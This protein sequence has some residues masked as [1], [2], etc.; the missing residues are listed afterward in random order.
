MKIVYH[1][2]AHCTDDDRLLRCLLKNRARLSAAGVVVP[3]PARYRRLLRD[4]AVQL[5][6]QRA[7][8]E[9]QALVLDQ[10]MDEAEAERLILSW[11]SFL[12]FPQWA[13]QDGLYPMAGERIRAF[14][15]IFPEIAAEF[16]L[17]IR[18]P[19]TFLPALFDK[20]KVKSLPE[21]LDGTDPMALRW[22]DVIARIR[23][24]NPGITLTIWCDEDTPLI[25]PDVLARVT[26]MPEGTVFD[27]QDELLEMLMSAEGFGHYQGYVVDQ[28]PKSA[29]HRRRIVAAFLSKF[30]RPD[31]LEMEIEMPGW[32]HDTVARLTEAYEA[33]VATIAAIPGVRVILP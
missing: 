19:A 13:L 23:A 24:E 16:C 18:N 6:G 7:S 30:A 20:Q 14:T 12:S 32:T 31:Q 1:L 33:D 10:I 4:T 26:G 21:F 8:V 25:W 2:G 29:A 5:R 3:G 28:P 11:D 27:D 17:S 15:Q 22:S 9:T